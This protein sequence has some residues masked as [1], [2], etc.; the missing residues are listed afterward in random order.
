MD[1]Q[2]LR[3]AFQEVE[4]SIKRDADRVWDSLSEDDK[5]Y[6]FCK[7]VS[8]IHKG[9]VEERGSYRYVLYQ[10]FGFDMGSYV[11]AQ[12]SGYLDLHNLLFDGINSDARIKKFAEFAGCENKVED[13]FKN[14]YKM[15]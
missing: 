15:L 12:L 4:L 13:F 2:E 11:P 9:E 8:L 3:A 7:V 10:V 6:A 14:E 5:L 1:P